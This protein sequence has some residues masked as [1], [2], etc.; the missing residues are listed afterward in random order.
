MTMERSG[1]EHWSERLSRWSGLA[2]ILGG[3][4]LALASVL[5]ALEPTGCIGVECGIRPMRTATPLVSIL[6]PVA[7]ILILVGLGGLTLMARRSA[8]GTALAV[9]GLICVGAG[10]LILF[11]AG[12]IQEVSFDGDFPW[13]PF[14][15]LPGVL[16]V[17]VGVVLLGVFVLRSGVLPRWLG[18]LLAASAALLV[19][20][21]EQVW[22]VLLA[23]PFGLTIAVV[24][25]FMWTSGTRRHE[26]A[27]RPA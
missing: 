3:L 15:V 7:A 12:L 9:S 13:M 24:G 10:L 8:R 20:A 18:I 26:T 2:A 4:L 25:F 16:A 22:T 17:I 27:V 11:V 23:V 19:L 6:G 21:N 5:H 14:F 1:D